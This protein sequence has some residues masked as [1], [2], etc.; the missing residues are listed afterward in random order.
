[1]KSVSVA[2]IKR[3]LARRPQIPAGKRNGIAVE[4]KITPAG[5]PVTVVSMRNALLMGMNPMKIVFD[6]PLDTRY[7]SDKDGVWMTDSLQELWQ[8]DQAVG[9]LRGR[10]L[11]GG[12]GLGVAT[13][14]ASYNPKVSSVRTIEKDKHIVGLIWPHLRTECSDCCVDDLYSYLAH[15]TPSDYDSAFLDIWRGTGEFT[16][17]EQIVPLRRLC[18]NRIKKVFCWQEDEML[19][20]MRSAL[21]VACSIDDMTVVNYYQPFV[22]YVRKK[23]IDRPTLPNPKTDSVVYFAAI[24]SLKYNGGIAKYPALRAA[25]EHYLRPGT[26]RWEKDFGDAWDRLVKD[27]NDHH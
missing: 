14:L 2:C 16:W 1:M 26:D 11:I 7:L 24:T 13:T 18:R 12:L 27:K 6:T 17:K 25:V 20:Q 5:E 8:C 15:V 10:V 22:E 23:N 3:T 19:G 9:K 4:I 21:P